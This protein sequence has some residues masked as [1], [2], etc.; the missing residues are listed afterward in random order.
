MCQRHTISV[1]PDKRNEVE[2][3]AVQSG[4]TATTRDKRRVED[5]RL[6]DRGLRKFGQVGL[7]RPV[8]ANHHSPL[9]FP[10][11]LPSTLKNK[12]P[13]PSFDEGGGHFI[14][15]TCHGA[16]LWMVV[17]GIFQF[18][19]S[20]SSVS[21]TTYRQSGIF[22][23]VAAIDGGGEEADIAIIHVIFIVLRGT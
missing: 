11:T 3:S 10:R 20:S 14:V 17:H 22:G 7:R 4:V 15:E 2:C 19:D 21:D 5:T 23:Q 1:T 8:G 16:S 18:S 9:R 13:P 6:I 12:N